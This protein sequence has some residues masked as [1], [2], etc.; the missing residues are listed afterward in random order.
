M[1][2]TFHIACQLQKT[3]KNGKEQTSNNESINSVLK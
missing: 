1:V 2:Q 3:M